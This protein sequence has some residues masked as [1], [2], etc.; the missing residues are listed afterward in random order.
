LTLSPGRTIFLPVGRPTVPV[1]LVARRETCDLY[2]GRRVCDQITIIGAAKVQLVTRNLTLV[3]REAAFE[4]AGIADHA[5]APA[6]FDSA[7]RIQLPTES[8]DT[9]L[10]APGASLARSAPPAAYL[11]PKSASGPPGG[12]Q[13][14]EHPGP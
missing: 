3:D 7:A 8:A 14:W 9:Q 13:S 5:D 11:L 2:T 1:A 10:P 4:P 6:V 12:S